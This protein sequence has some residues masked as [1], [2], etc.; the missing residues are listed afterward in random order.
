MNVLK[1]IKEKLLLQPDQECKIKDKSVWLM[2]WKETSK[3]WFLI[4]ELKLLKKL[5]LWKN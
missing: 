3:I 2:T 1:E 4:K 5:K